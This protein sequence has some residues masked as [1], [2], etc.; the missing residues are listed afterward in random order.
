MNTDLGFNLQVLEKELGVSPRYFRGM[1]GH[2]FL[3]MKRKDGSEP[4]A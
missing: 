3:R 4:V 2:F 1:L